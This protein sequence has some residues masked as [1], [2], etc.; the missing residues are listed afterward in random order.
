MFTEI[1]TSAMTA[2]GK[3]ASN[4]AEAIQ[5]VQVF[6][7]I[8]FISERKPN[9]VATMLLRAPLYSATVEV[10]ISLLRPPL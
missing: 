1:V 4:S 5:R 2:R 8:V 3:S 10:L 9:R 7:R 6:E